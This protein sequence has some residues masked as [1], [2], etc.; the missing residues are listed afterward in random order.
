ME[1]IQT[2]E[3]LREIMGQPL[4]IVPKK[5]HRQLNAKAIEFIQNSP[6]MFISTSDVEGRSTVAPKG[7]PA[8]FVQVVNSTT[9]RI[10]ERKGNRLLMSLQNLLDN[11]QIG[12]VFI[13]PGNV[14]ENRKR[15]RDSTPSHLIMPGGAAIDV[16][17][18]IW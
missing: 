17:L 4:P 16:K 14:V 15:D 5:I 18:Q 9:L 12:L 13:V 10:P 2:R 7:D 3:R 1:R 8:G 11:D 6:L